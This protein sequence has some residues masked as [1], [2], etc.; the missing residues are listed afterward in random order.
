[1]NACL[2][3]SDYVLTQICLFVNREQIIKQST[4]LSAEPMGKCMQLYESSQRVQRSWEHSTP[5]SQQVQTLLSLIIA[6]SVVAEYCIP[7]T[8]E[9]FLGF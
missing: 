8:P 5:I 6:L 9:G 4:E 3:L 7:K 2:S 1:M